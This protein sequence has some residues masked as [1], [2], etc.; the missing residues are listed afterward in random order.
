MG[1]EVS[2]RCSCRP[3]KRDREPIIGKLRQQTLAPDAQHDCEWKPPIFLL[4][5]SSMLISRLLRQSS[6]SAGASVLYRYSTVAAQHTRV[7]F[8]GTF[9]HAYHLVNFDIGLPG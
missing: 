3:D 5:F 9:A 1:E 2:S 8:T 6:R 4:P 7:N